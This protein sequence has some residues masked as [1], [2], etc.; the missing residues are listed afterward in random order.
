MLKKLKKYFDVERTY[1]QSYTQLADLVVEKQEEYSKLSDDEL[2]GKTEEFKQLIADGTAPYDLRVEAFATVREA[3][4][5]SLGMEPFHVQIMGAAALYDGNISE[6]KTGEGKTLTATLAVYLMA[7]EGKGVHVITVNDYLARRDSEEMGVLYNFLGLTVGLNDRELSADEKRE[8]YACDITY[9][10][11]SEL[12][13]DYL[14][15]NMALHLSQ[16]VL[17]G[18]RYA[19][20]DEVDSILIDESR[21]PL[22]ISGQPKKT[23]NLYTIVDALVKNMTED[24]D[25][26]MNVRDKNAHLLEAGID[27]V[28]QTLAKGNLFDLENSD[29]LHAINQALKAVWCMHKDVDYVTKDGKIIIVDQFTGRLMEGRSYSDG[30]HQALEA[31]EHVDIQEE[32]KTLATITYQNFFRLYDQLSGMTGTAKT[33]EEEFLKTYGMDVIQIPTNK[34]IIRLDRD[35]RI[36]KSKAAKYAHMIEFIRERHAHGQPILIGTVA[37]ETSEEIAEE[38]H[39]HNIKHNVL[40]AKKHDEEAQIIKDAGQVGAVTIATNMAGRGTDIKLS[41]EVRMLEE[42]ESELEEC[43]VNPAGLLIVGTE[44]HEARR[45]DNQ[46]RGRSG[47]QGDHGESVFYVSFEDDLMKRFMN[48]TM[49]ALLARF[50]DEMLEAKAITKRI[51]AAQTQIEGINYDSRKNLLKYDDVLREQRENI[52]GQRDYILDNTDITNDTI[53]MIRE[54]VE[55]QVD[56]YTTNGSTEDL[57]E[58]VKLN[59]SNN[60]VELDVEGDLV[61]QIMEYAQA[62]VDSKIEKLTEEGFNDF[63][64]TVIIK[65]LDTVWINHIDE[66]QTLRQTIGLRGYGQVNPLHEYQGEGRRM[67]EEM[68]SSIEADSTKFI[69]KGKVYSN[70]QRELVQRRMES[71]HGNITGLANQNG[72]TKSVKKQGRNELCECGSGK[73]FKDCHGR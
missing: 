24:H 20:V 57:V 70:E 62:E 60:D 34:P 6:M 66:M 27:K 29:L 64:K 10:T 50:P 28:E 21:T 35:D 37:I 51:E 5:R 1:L 26:K 65:V 33:E 15:D 49:E 36:F 25:F 22:I 19:I 3:A 11:N 58:F 12:G 8:Q 45:I 56:Y 40:N 16:R 54:Y 44:R 72:P 69:L 32:T 38:L 43:I 18:L 46:L 23:Q 41:T 17:R 63:A 47:R 42:Y 2:K 4:K 48:P 61:E 53:E 30:L 14:R 7:L 68:V 13:F 39:K 9:T 71:D 59:I 31:K 73:K 55:G 52:Y 67:F